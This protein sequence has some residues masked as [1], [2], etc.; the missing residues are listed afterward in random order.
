[1]E[2]FITPLEMEKTAYIRVSEN[3]TEWTRD[4]MEQFY[5]AFP[6]FMSF[7]VRV[8]F[9]QRDEQKGYA[10]GAIHIEN[11]SGIVVPVVIKNRELFP[12]D[13]AIFNG[14]VMPLNDYTIQSYLSGKSPFQRTVSRE[15]GDITALLFNAGNIG[16]TR[17]MPMETY[18]AAELLDTVLPL[19]T[20]A[21]REAVLKTAADERVAEGYKQN[22]TA[23]L[24]LKIAAATTA[25]VDIK[26]TVE[27]QVH[28]SIDRDIWYIY[29]SGEFEYRG[30][31][32]NSKVD[33]P[34]E[35]EMNVDDVAAMGAFVKTSAMTKVAEENKLA[36]MALLPIENS[37]RSLVVFDN[38]DYIEMPNRSLGQTKVAFFEAK[39]DL[40]EMGAYGTIQLDENTFSTPFT[41]DRFWA[42]GKTQHVEGS[43]VLNKVAYATHPSIKE[44]IN[45]GNVTWLPENAIF[46]K[47]ATCQKSMNGTNAVAKNKVIKTAGGYLVDGTEL[48]SYVKTTQPIELHKAAWAL[49]QCGASETD[50]TKLASMHDGDTLYIYDELKTPISDVV[51][52]IVDTYHQECVEAAA[53]VAHISKN[54]VKEASLIPDLPTVD[55]VLALNFVNKDSIGAFIQALP[56]LESA[57]FSVADMLIKARV[58]VELVSEGALR[59]VM[60]GLSDIVQVLKGVTTLKGDK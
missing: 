20:P 52:K 6:Y 45:D 3:P 11:G 49:V 25:D 16:Y 41:V 36:M 26:S 39:P 19:T 51:N 30:I 33:D 9:K 43:T 34:L 57:M 59:K 47:L 24:I 29:K 60:F 56:T 42:E 1:M 14:T 12:F 58:G 5:N 22:G 50:V 48:S 32:G 13:L 27:E 53:K 37:D 40:I 2:L 15:T 17:E 4:V 55:K 46:F 18:K 10:V 21:E 35:F 7:P 23:N 54:F 28:K 44:T 31:F 38:H 8:E